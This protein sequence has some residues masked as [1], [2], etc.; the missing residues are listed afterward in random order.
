PWTT[1]LAWSAAC[2]ASR[3]STRRSRAASALLAEKEHRGRRVSC[4]RLKKGA[5][6]KAMSKD[7]SMSHRRSPLIRRSA[8]E[9][10]SAP[11][12]TPPR[13]RC[14]HSFPSSERNSTPTSI[15]ND[16][17]SE[18]NRGAILERVGHD[19]RGGFLLDF[20]AVHGHFR[21]DGGD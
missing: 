13:C 16:V 6:S 1:P 5:E 2:G 19:G 3:V 7:F 21:D 9:I 8:W 14:T 12:E 10:P 18:E 11:W 15:R 20:R 4:A 17:L